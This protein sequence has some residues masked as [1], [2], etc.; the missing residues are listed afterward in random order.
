VPTFTCQE[1]NQRKE[2]N[3]FQLVKL[4]SFACRY[5]NYEQIHYNHINNCLETAKEI[6]EFKNRAIEAIQEEKKKPC[7]REALERRRTIV[8]DEA[9]RRQKEEIQG[10]IKDIKDTINNNKKKALVIL[11][12]VII[13]PAFI[14]RLIKGR[15]KRVAKKSLP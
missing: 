3:E 5:D 1:K 10:K 14:K 11:T 13:G 2:I 4:T 9:F 7:F 12:L 8:R 6:N 15:K